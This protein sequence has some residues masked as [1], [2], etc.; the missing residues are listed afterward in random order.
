MGGA[1]RSQ[2]QYR[3]SAVP[4]AIWDGRGWVDGA[5]RRPG[6]EIIRVDKSASGLRRRTMLRALTLAARPA[7]QPYLAARA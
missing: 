6:G 5:A 3:C 4:A 1:T 7:A 2:A